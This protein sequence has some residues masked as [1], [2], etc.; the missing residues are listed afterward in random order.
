MMKE[1][2]LTVLIVLFICCVQTVSAISVSSLTI[3][4]SG[5]MTPA[6]PVIVSFRIENS[7]IFPS[8]GEIQMYTD[9]EEPNWTYTIIVNG[10]ENLRPVLQGQTLTISGFELNYKTHDEVSVR[11]TLEGKAPIV[12]S[13]SNQIIIR[14]SEVDSDGI[15]TTVITEYYHHIP[16]TNVTRTLPPVI[17]P[18]ERFSI[19]LS[20]SPSLDTSSGWMVIEIIPF[21][22]TFI[23]SNA[24]VFRQTGDHEY[25]LIQDSAAP[26][27]YTLDA[28]DKMGIYRESG[29]AVDST[30]NNQIPVVGDTIIRIGSIIQNYRNSTTGFVERADAARARDDYGQHKITIDE[31]F[32]VLQAFFLGGFISVSQVP[33]MVDFINGDTGDDP[34]IAKSATIATEAG[35]PVSLS[36][37]YGPI[38]DLMVTTEDGIPEFSVVSEKITNLPDG[39]ASPNGTIY[40]YLHIETPNTP[41]TNLSQITLNFKVPLN[42]I[43]AY[44]VDTGDI[45]LMRYYDGVWTTLPTEFLD[46]GPSYAHFRSVSSGLSYFAISSLKPDLSTNQTQSE[47]QSSEN[48]IQYSSLSQTQVATTLETPVSTYSFEQYTPWPTD[49]STNKSTPM[50]TGLGIIALIVTGILVI[51]RTK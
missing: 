46:A 18:G 14:I 28:P 22:F 2:K 47:N 11:V 50:G 8:D 37:V 12:S 10:I 29:M 36:F 30:K 49:T 44:L 48:P 31:L 6:T 4:P 38:T 9:L 13:T 19:M 17:N 20:P 51:R 26:I 35:E 41:A 25:Q 32:A 34:N 23:E 3:N 39:V 40:V 42:W 43:D 5:Q 24:Y 33:K 7:G 27:T 1:L 16:E 21:G 15:I 45:V